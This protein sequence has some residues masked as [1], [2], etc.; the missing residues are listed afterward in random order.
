MRKPIHATSD[1]PVL[2]VTVFEKGK[3]NIAFQTHGADPSR[4]V[5]DV[6]KKLPDDEK[7]AARPA[8]RKAIAGIL[9]LHTTAGMNTCQID[10]GGRRVRFGIAA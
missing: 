10:V 8:M 4:I 7:K 2:D 6:A 9:D 5:R 3:R 1:A